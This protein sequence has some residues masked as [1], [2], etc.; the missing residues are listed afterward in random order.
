MQEKLSTGKGAGHG[1]EKP[2]PAKVLGAGGQNPVLV[3]AFRG[4]H[5]ESVH[6]GAIAVVDAAGRV[7]YAAG[8]TGAFIFPRSACKMIQAI[9]LVES[10]AAERYALSDKEL[11]LACASHTGEPFHVETVRAWLARIGCSEKIGR[12]HV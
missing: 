12:A 4:G 9:P 1:G 6:R 10:G 11:A 5:V 3:E 7:I 8:D 2:A